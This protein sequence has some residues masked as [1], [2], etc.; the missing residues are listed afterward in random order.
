MKSGRSFGQAVQALVKEG[1]VG[2]KSLEDFT[3]RLK[4]PAPLG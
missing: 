2:T 3:H 4:N 1:A